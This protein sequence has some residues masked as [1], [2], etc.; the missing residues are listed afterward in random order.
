MISFYAS[1]QALAG[2]RREKTLRHCSETGVFALLLLLFIEFSQ[3]DKIL[4]EK[5]KR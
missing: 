3:I 1:V 4:R 2:T 5:G